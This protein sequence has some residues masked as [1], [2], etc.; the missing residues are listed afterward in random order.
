MVCPNEDAP[1]A[2]GVYPLINAGNA[3]DAAFNCSA[4]TGDYAPDDFAFRNFLQEGYDN[5]D[6]YVNGLAV[7][8]D[9]DGNGQID[10]NGGTTWMQYCLADFDNDGANEL[11]L[12]TTFYS[13]GTYS[14]DDMALLHMYENYDGQVVEKNSCIMD[15]RG[16][17]TSPGITFYNND[18]V[19]WDDNYN[20]F[21]SICIY[22]F[23]DEIR[24]MVGINESKYL[25]YTPSND[26]S[27]LVSRYINAGFFVDDYRDIT[28]EEYNAELNSILT[29][30]VISPTVHPVT[31]AGIDEGFTE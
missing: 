21:R 22:P 1:V 17:F 14:V 31:T 12:R 24:N 29:G 25:A 2:T 20:G 18:V 6:D 19:Y 23:S 13:A 30:Q 28:E 10:R 11:L 8:Y 5:A 4:S 15:A 27:G 26:G 9:R 3:A 16:D 7:Y